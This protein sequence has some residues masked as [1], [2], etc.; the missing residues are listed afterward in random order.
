MW[1]RLDA[2]IGRVMFHPP[3]I[4]ICQM[5]RQS[6]YA[7]SRALWFGCALWIFAH[8]D[9]LFDRTI[10]GLMCIALMYSAGRR[11]DV[12]KDG[13]F[14]SRVMWWIFLSIDLW[15]FAKGIGGF[16]QIGQDIV[17]LF[18]EYALTIRTIPPRRT[19]EKAFKGK[20]AHG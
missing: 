15:G 11:A 1:R 18:A 3:I 2:W 12:P 10:M 5:T 7:L 17:I 16:R 9:G 14:T 20:E 8:A 4:W 19:R 6:Q 13:Y